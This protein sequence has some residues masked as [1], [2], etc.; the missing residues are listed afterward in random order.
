MW[1]EKKKKKKNNVPT[2]R[3]RRC[4]V[5]ATGWL[6]DAGCAA[7]YVVR[8]GF[9]QAEM[10]GGARALHAGGCSR[11]RAAVQSG[12]YKS[13]GWAWPPAAAVLSR[14]RTTERRRDDDARTHTPTTARSGRERGE[15]ARIESAR[16][17]QNADSV[18]FCV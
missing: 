18:S 15:R 4:A 9:S 2:S 16:A 1:R 17:R 13:A 3:S 14:V 5:E 11:V 6:C 8:V 10:I 12:A 7:G